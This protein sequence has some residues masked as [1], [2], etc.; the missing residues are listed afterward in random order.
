M[1][2]FAL[3][4]SLGLGALTFA[5]SAPATP[6]TKESFTF[7]DMFV[8]ADSCP[9][10][11]FTGSFTETDTIITFSATRVQVHVAFLGTLSANGKTLTDNDHYTVMFDPTTT[12]IKYVGTVFNFQAPGVGNLLID[13]GSIIYDDSTTPPT[14]I[15]I[16]GPHPAFFGD[17]GPICDYLADP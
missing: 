9:G 10:L 7:S 4:L 15:H 2:R 5:S 16:G 11:T 14:V 12:V 3:L 1:R 6:P 13:A 17:F 8:N